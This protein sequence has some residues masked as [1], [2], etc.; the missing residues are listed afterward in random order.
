MMSRAHT[1]QAFLQ[2]LKLVKQIRKSKKGRDLFP[3][4]T[5]DKNLGFQVRVRN[6][7]CYIGCFLQQIKD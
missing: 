7:C 5:L 6:C 2:I 1:L 3:F 4:Q